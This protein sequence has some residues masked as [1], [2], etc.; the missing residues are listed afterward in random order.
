[1][2]AVAISQIKT[3]Q[4]VKGLASFEEARTI[5]ERLAK[6]NPSVTLFQN[7]LAI[8]YRNIGT[9]HR[10]SSRPAQA[11]SSYEQ[12]LKI[13]Q[14]LSLEHPESSEFHSELGWTLN[15]MATVDLAERRFD[16]AR[17]ELTAAIEWQRKALAATPNRPDFRDVLFES[18]KNLVLAANGLG[19]TDEADQARRELAV[20]AADDPAK[21]PLDARLA[22][23]LA[24]SAK[25]K[26]DAERIQLASQACEM[27]LHAGSTRLYAEALANKPSLSDDRQAQHRYNAACAAALAV[28]GLGKNE[29]PLDDAARAKLRRQ[30][31][32]WLQTELAAWA[33]VFESGPP[34]ARGLVAK[35]LKHWQEDTDR[36]G[37]RD[38]QAI[39]GLSETEAR[40]LSVALDRRCRPPRESPSPH[41]SYRVGQR[42]SALLRHAAQT[43]VKREANQ[44]RSNPASERWVAASC[45]KMPR[46]RS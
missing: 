30:A 31:L 14:R 21:A 1:M 23:I 25:P 32:D 16:K 19:R 42:P 10:D 38:D 12:A 29:P 8:S 13:H 43:A 34:Q 33:K 5:Q 44:S 26:D 2:N 22:A 46:A 9:L 39:A 41:R 11:L 37:V 7:E 36:A 20:L 35:T 45:A 40:C 28:A 15:A 24:G 27:A 17:A 4:P 6:A 18:L 3:G